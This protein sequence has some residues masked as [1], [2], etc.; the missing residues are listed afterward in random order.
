MPVREARLLLLEEAAVG[1]QDLAQRRRRLRRIDGAFEAQVH[2]ARQVS[3][4][5][6]VR[7]RQH[8]GIELLRIEWK[9]RPILEAQILEALKHPAVDEH[10]TLTA[11]EQVLGT[12]D[13]LGR[14]EEGK[15]HGGLVTADW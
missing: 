12:G 6:D 14:A 7:V 2:E 4:V 5:I 10:L 11:G 9:M 3:A 13:G 1:Q 15:L 8:D